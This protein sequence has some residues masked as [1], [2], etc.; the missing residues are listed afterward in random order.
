MRHSF[1]AREARLIEF[2][3][4]AL[5]VE[6]PHIALIEEFNLFPLLSPTVDVC[7]AAH[8]DTSV[9]LL[10]VNPDFVCKTS[11]L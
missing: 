1:I 2:R 7:L 4:V 9:R 10:A 5:D 6:A 8:P 11:S 3:V